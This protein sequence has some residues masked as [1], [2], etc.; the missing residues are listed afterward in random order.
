M[1]CH[2]KHTTI[3]AVTR[4]LQRDTGLRLIIF[5]I[6]VEALYMQAVHHDLMSDQTCKQTNVAVGWFLQ[7]SILY[8]R[9]CRAQPSAAIQ[10]FDDI[11][12]RWLLTGHEIDGSMN[13]SMVRH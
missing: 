11:K 2:R 4:P 3:S 10:N 8:F 9:S 1:E 6:E 7:R 5:A 12:D 13:Q